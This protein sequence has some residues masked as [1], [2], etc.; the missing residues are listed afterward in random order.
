[1]VVNFEFRGDE[2]IENLN[3]FEELRRWGLLKE[4]FMNAELSL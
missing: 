3:I 2:P 1:M 4:Y